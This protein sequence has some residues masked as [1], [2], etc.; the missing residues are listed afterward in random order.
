MS[1]EKARSAVMS[2]WDDV[3]GRMLD[4]AD[5]IARSNDMSAEDMQN[6]LA[7]YCGY[8]VSDAWM[9]YCLEQ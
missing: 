4:Q 7:T 9:E 8:E 3:L 5:D 1:D 6:L 2:A